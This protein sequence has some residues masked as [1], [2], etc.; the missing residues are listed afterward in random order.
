MSIQ[1]KS[2][3]NVEIMPNSDTNKYFV[4]GII[5]LVILVISMNI[6]VYFV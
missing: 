2:P 6:L 5:F 3:N 4:F 1:T